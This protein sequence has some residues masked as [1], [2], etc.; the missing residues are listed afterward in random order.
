LQ[1]RQYAVLARIVAELPDDEPVAVCGDF[2]APADSDVHRQ[3]L[4]A[5]RL[6]DAFDG[7][8]PPTFSTEY[9]PAGELPHCIDFILVH[10]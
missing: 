7:R 6:H 4:S 3:L 5:T 10:P 1:R 2:N 9:L 8:C